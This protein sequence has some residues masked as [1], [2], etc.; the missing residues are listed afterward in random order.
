VILGGEAGVDP[1][2]AKAP[3]SLAAL[4]LGAI[5]LRVREAE[6]ARPARDEAAALTRFAL[7][8]LRAPEPVAEAATTDVRI[9]ARPLVRGVKRS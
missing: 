1:E 4:V 9:A 3:R 7:A 8:G 2:D 5:V 6:A